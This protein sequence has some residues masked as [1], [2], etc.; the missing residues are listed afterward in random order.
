MIADCFKYYKGCQVCQ[1][2]DDL[3]LVP[4]AELHPIIKPWP[5]RGWGLDFIGEIHPSSSKGHR[6]VLVAT[7]Y[8]TKWTE[9]VALKNMTHKEVIELITEHIIHRFGIPQTLTT[10]Q[11][12]SFMS[13]EV[14]EF[15][16]LYRI[17]LLNSSLYY[18]QANGQDESSNRT[19][20]NLIKKKISDNPKHWHK[21]LSE[22]LWAHRISK[23]SVSPFEL[24][25]GQE[26]VLPMEISLNAVRF[27]RQNNL[28]VTDYY[29][30]MM[31]NIDE[32]TDKR[33][34]ALGAIEKDKIM[35]ARAYNKKVKAKSFQVGDLVW[36][37]ILPLR[38]KDRKFGKRSPS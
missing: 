5:F 17:K 21:I 1:K 25:Y 9:A 27:A 26:A 15:A 30:S 33:V 8:F 14:R 28:T 38:N 34:I 23:H 19:L 10:D 16:E 36:K 11:G 37:T 29:N 13:K 4:A 20:I 32:V 24:V 35:V 22:A 3:Q 18:A 31:D 7:D 6:F 12:T 2:F